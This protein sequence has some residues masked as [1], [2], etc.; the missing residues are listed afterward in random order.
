MSGPWSGQ[1]DTV[2]LDELDLICAVLG[3]GVTELLLP[4]PD[5]V[6]EP[7]P[8]DVQPAA[9]G[10]EARARVTS[11]PRAGRYLPPR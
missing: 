1:P 7:V 4:E 11:R 8:D 5:Q 9:A 2:R 3:C 6:A 10:G